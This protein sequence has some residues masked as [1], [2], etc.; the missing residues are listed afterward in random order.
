ML[1]DTSVDPRVKPEDDGWDGRKAI[2]ASGLFL[3]N[4]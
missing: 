1:M 4:V 2:H 3:A